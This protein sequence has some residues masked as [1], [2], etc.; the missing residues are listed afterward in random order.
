MSSIE[1]ESGIE[2]YT[3]NCPALFAV[4]DEEPKVKFYGYPG[5][6]NRSMELAPG[7]YPDLNAPNM[8]VGRNDVDSVIVPGNMIVTGYERGFYNSGCNDC[9]K[10]TLEGGMYNDLDN[11]FRGLGKNDMD[12]ITIVRKK[13]WDEFKMDCCYNQGTQQQCGQFWGG[14]KTGACTNMM[15]TKC[16]AGQIKSN[17]RCRDWCVANPGECDVAMTQYCAANPTDPI[18]S[19]LRSPLKAPACFDRACITTPGYRTKTMA[20]ISVRCPTVVEC[21]QSVIIDKNSYNNI[22]SD[23]RMQQTCIADQ[24]GQKVT[25][26]QTPGTHNAT[27]PNIAVDTKDYTVNITPNPRPGQNPYAAYPPAQ[28]PLLSPMMLIILVVVLL[29]TVL[30]VVFMGD[31]DSGD[32]EYNPYVQYY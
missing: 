19:C 12:S 32:Y 18:C 1:I 6:A 5:C 27:Q 20:D 3:D 24:S 21:N 31:D 26:A 8:G 16:D 29:A 22:V 13:P 23:L 11:P 28:N 14:A 30:A 25:D 17:P 9:R 10:V 2:Q 15:R 7:N 4:T